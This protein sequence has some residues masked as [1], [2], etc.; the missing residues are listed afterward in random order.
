MLS[1]R[2]E[3][4]FVVGLSVTRGDKSFMLPFFD[5]IDSCLSLLELALLEV[6]TPHNRCSIYRHYL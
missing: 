2:K 3:P 6:F 5:V 4:L 1:V